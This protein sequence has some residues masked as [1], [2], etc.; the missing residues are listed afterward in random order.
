MPVTKPLERMFDGEPKHV[1]MTAGEIAAWWRQNREA[2][3]FGTPSPQWRKT[4]DEVLDLQVGRAVELRAADGMPLKVTLK[5][6]RES[7]SDDGTPVTTTELEVYSGEWYAGG[8]GNPDHHDGYV[9]TSMT[10]T[11]DMDLR[12]TGAFLP[13]HN[14]GRV[15]VKLMLHVGRERE[16]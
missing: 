4:L 1:E 15:R 7:W 6:Y 13:T 2:F 11:W 10:G 3:G 9:H 12:W 8:L 16:G 14:A 5:Q